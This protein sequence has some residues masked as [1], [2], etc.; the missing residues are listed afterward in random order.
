MA[1][2]NISGDQARENWESIRAELGLDNIPVVS[3]PIRG[4]R[5]SDNY[6]QVRQSWGVEHGQLPM[7]DV[8]QPIMPGNTFHSHL[9]SDFCLTTALNNLGNTGYS[10]L[11]DLTGGGDSMNH[12]HYN[13]TPT[14]EMPDDDFTETYKGYKFST[15]YDHMPSRFASPAGTSIHD[16]VRS[17]T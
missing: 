16:T 4:V 5:F 1:D 10:A 6:D 12:G 14:G 2:L 9:Y 8:Q 13:A 17:S 3:Q 7:T 15:F 11:S